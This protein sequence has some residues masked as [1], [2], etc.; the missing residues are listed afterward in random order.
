[1]LGDG[2]NDAPALAEATIG[3]ARGAAGSPVT[4]DTADIAPMGGDLGSSLAVTLMTFP[5]VRS[6]GGKADRALGFEGSGRA[7][8]GAHDPG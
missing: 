1:M 8:R 2:V 7:A 6:V 4:I 3:R 5:D